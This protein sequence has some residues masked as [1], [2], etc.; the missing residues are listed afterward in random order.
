MAPRSRS[1]ALALAAAAASA[2]CGGAAACV[3]VFPAD[4]D[5]CAAGCAAQGAVG[6]EYQGTAFGYTG[7]CKCVMGQGQKVRAARQRAA[8]FCTLGEGARGRRP[9]PPPPPPPLTRGASLD[10]RADPDRGVPG[11]RRGAAAAA[12]ARVCL[13]RGVRR[14]HAGGRLEHVRGGGG[15]LYRR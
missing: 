4:S 15:R 6:H 9:P 1:L 10:L 8:V 2:A 14:R 5:A 3:D 11:R 7:Y 13:P 12:A